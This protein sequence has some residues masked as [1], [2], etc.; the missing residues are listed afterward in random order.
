MHTS[1]C[2]RSDG[3]WF[4]SRD[5]THE[6]DERLRTALEQLKIELNGISGYQ[7]TTKGPVSYALESKIKN[8]INAIDDALKVL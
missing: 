2:F 3:D 8:C 5:C 6:K 1:R 4:C 7:Y